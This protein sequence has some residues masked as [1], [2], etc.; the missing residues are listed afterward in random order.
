MKLK[1]LKLSFCYLITFLYAE[2]FNESITFEALS[3]DLATD[4]VLV[5]DELFKLI[6]MP[7][8][9][10]LGCSKSSTYFAKN[11]KNLLTHELTVKDR[12]N[13]AMPWFLKAN[14]DLKPNLLNWNLELYIF[15]ESVNRANNIAIEGKNPELF[16]KQYLNEIRNFFN[17]ICT[18]NIFDIIFIDPGI[19]IRGDFVNEAFN[20][21]DIIVAH[22]TNF[23][24]HIYGW[25][26]IKAPSNYTKIHFNYGSGT[27][28]WVK[29]ERIELIN[30]LK[31][32]L[33]SKE[34]E[35][36]LQPHIPTQSP[37]ETV[38][39]KQT[40]IIKEIYERHFTIDSSE[41]EVDTEKL[42]TSLWEQLSSTDDTSN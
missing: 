13:F 26:K 5:F 15:N 28:I 24:P 29:N 23:N 6:P 34:C 27:S 22:D 41:Q 42:Q 7:H 4:H 11:C 32:K 30:E 18:D 37:Q 25:T 19:H 12:F 17:K 1:Y 31:A 21:S 8:L 14:K 20:R 36:K 2:N 16:D 38:N 9:L 3:K 35:L 10:E 39:N 33:Q 40:S